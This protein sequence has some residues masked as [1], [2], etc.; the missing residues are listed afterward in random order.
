MVELITYSLLQTTSTSFKAVFVK[1][2]K[3]IVHDNFNIYIYI[4][5]IC[6][7]GRMYFYIRATVYIVVSHR[8]ALIKII[9]LIIVFLS[10]IA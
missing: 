10:K 1:N 2:S 9:L 8:H 4:Q 7:Y 3:Q 5:I 6:E